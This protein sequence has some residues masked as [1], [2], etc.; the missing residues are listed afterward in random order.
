MLTLQ[1]ADF[2]GKGVKDS[3]PQFSQVE[4]LLEEILAEEACFSLKDL[5]INGQDLIELGFEPGP[6][7]GACLGALL[8]QVQDE[9]LP[10]EKEA[11]LNAAKFIL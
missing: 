8:E 7:M 9:V 5:A 3:D 2:S 1:K 10:N 6:A 11:L 4:V